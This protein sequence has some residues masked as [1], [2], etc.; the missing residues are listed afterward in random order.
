MSKCEKC[1][2]LVDRYFF[3]ADKTDHT[4]DRCIVALQARVAA[5]EAQLKTAR[6]ALDVIAARDWDKGRD[7]SVQIALSAIAALGKPEGR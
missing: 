5:L 1:G 2:T 7:R 4:P 6:E 3:E